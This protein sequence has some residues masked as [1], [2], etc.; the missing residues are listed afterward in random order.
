[1]DL[2]ILCFH[3]VRASFN[4]DPYWGA[5]ETRYLDQDV[6]EEFNSAEG[7][8]IIV[9]G[10]RQKTNQ[11]EWIGDYEGLF[12]TTIRSGLLDLPLFMR[13]LSESFLEIEVEIGIRHLKA[14]EAFA[15]E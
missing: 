12:S 10:L 1:M 15:N 13:P 6:P 7:N 3:H 11:V 8:K 14:G 9:L 5:T 4:G 2:S